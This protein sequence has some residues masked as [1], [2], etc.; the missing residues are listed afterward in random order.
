MLSEDRECNSDKVNNKENVHYTVQIEVL[1]TFS[2]KESIS[3]IPQ[4]LLMLSI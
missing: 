3:R 4:I 1:D 2:D